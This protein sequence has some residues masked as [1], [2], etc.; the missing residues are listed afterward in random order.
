VLATVLV[1]DDEPSMRLLLHA[2]IESDDYK[3]VEASDGDEAWALIQQL[4]PALVLLDVQM[5]GLTGLEI[6]SLIKGDPNLT[7]TRVILLT[8]K[9]LS[10]D[11]EA[12]MKAGAD[13]YLSKPFSPIDLL[14][15]VEE[16]LHP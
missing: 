10:S 4:T 2:T 14:A 5:P 15:R 6:L 7:S 13:F 8:A 11:V 3:V 1:A 12:G 16:A 9:A